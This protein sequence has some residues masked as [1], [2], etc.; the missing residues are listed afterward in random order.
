M[1]SR[2]SAG[3]IGPDAAPA[4]PALVAALNGPSARWT[5]AGDRAT[6]A[7]AAI[8]ANK[9]QADLAEFRDLGAARLKGFAEP[10]E[11][12]QVLGTSSV[13]NR[14]EA[15]RSSSLTPFVGRE[16][17][18]ELLLGRWRRA[19]AGDG[20]I[21]LLSGEAGIGKSRSA[22]SRSS[23]AETFGGSGEPTGVWRAA[24]R[25]AALRRVGVKLRMPSRASVPFIAGS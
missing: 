5:A 8:R 1:D 12:W 9:A 7:A 13:D 4:V 3:K 11:V 24:K 15:L 6:A 23:S 16:D 22:M 18:L 25:S 10:A 17:E 20:Q 19:K 14:F 21:V 2:L